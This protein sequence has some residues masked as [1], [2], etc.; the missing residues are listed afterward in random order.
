LDDITS[1]SAKDAG[2]TALAELGHKLAA[3]D[4]ADLAVLIA[5]A[6][7]GKEIAFTRSSADMLRLLTAFA[8]NLL[9]DL[10]QNE[11]GVGLEALTDDEVNELAAALLQL[12]RVSSAEV[13]RRKG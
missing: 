1:D 6:R 7:S 3:G 9:V 10:R 11:P 2:M 5:R 4:L 8:D 13:V 12:H